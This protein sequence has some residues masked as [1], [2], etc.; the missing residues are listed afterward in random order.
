MQE[1]RAGPGRDLVYNQ[2]KETYDDQ[3]HNSLQL[4]RHR[5]L[6]SKFFFRLR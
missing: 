1:E 6:L 5:L 3:V 4:D 2:E